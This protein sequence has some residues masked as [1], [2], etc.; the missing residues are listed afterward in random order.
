MFL[1]EAAAGISARYEGRL[2][3]EQIKIF[4]GRLG[5]FKLVINNQTVVSHSSNLHLRSE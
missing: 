3:I 2:H 4:T 5:E 1:Q